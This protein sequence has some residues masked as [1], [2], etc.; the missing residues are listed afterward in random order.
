MKVSKRVEVQQK[1]SPGCSPY[2]RPSQDLA[3]IG[4][5]VVDWNHS[6]TGNWAG[7]DEWIRQVA[8][9]RRIEV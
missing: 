5:N 7:L 4:A 9:D 6:R 2:N 3:R 8:T 1:A